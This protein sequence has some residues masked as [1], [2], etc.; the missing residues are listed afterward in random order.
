MISWVSRLQRIQSLECHTLFIMNPI[1]WRI[2][3]TYHTRIFLRKKL[4][5]QMTKSA[6]K[7]TI[8]VH[9][10]GAVVV[11]WSTSKRTSSWPLLHVCARTPSLVYGDVPQVLACHFQQLCTSIHH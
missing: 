5:M 3:L 10:T 9:L 7:W 6:C 8:R 1:S 11:T 4:V 2:R